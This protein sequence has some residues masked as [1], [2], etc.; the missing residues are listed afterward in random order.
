MSDSNWIEVCRTN[1]IE[2]DDVYEFIHDEK[3]YGIFRIEKGFFAIDGLCSHEKASLIDGYVHDDI[4]ECPK[5]NARFQITTGKALKRPA[6]TDLDTYEL[7]VEDS[8][9]KIKI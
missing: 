6:C 5:H 7:K 4:V 1:D 8:L 3:V 2:M 9:I